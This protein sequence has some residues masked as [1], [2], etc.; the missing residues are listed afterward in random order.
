MLRQF[1][2]VT[3]KTRGCYFLLYFDV[4][5]VENIALVE[6]AAPNSGAGSVTSRF[7]KPGSNLVKSIKKGSR[8]LLQFR[9]G[10]GTE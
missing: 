2:L 5:Y 3:D 10:L 6:L 9:D 1:E 8:K 4:S 7:K